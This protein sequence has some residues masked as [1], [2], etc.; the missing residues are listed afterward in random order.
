MNCLLKSAII[1]LREQVLV[2]YP[3]QIELHQF[4]QGEKGSHIYTENDIFT[5]SMFPGLQVRVG[6][7]FVLPEDKE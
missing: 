2:L 4:I 1:W 3:E 5:S 6:D 7:L